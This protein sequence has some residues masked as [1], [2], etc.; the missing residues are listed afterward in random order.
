MIADE[1]ALLS[2]FDCVISLNASMTALLRESGLKTPIVDL[3]IWDYLIEENL[4]ASLERGMGEVA[5]AGN[6]AKAPFISQLAQVAGVKF[7]LYGEGAADLDAALKP[8]CV[9]WRGAFSTDEVPAKIA[10]GWGLVWDGDS[11]DTCGGVYGEYLK[12]NTPHK[13]SLYIVAE[14]PVIV[15]REAAVAGYILQKGLGIAVESLRELPTALA[16]VTGEE[17]SQMLTNVREEKKRLTAGKNLEE[18]VEKA[19]KLVLGE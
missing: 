13:T 8:A 2:V 4:A 15:W 3:G 18:A 19:L 1:V 9:E 6:L 16:G 10:G 11:V 5:F 17:Y 14:R 12:Y 7:L